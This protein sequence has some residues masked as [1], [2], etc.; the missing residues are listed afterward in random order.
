MWCRFISQ[1]K[2]S[3]PPLT[4]TPNKTSYGNLM[5]L[6]KALC[7]TR[8]TKFSPFGS[9]HLLSVTHV[10]GTRQAPQF[11]TSVISSFAWTHIIQ[12]VNNSVPRFSSIICPKHTCC[13]NSCTKYMSLK[14]FSQRISFPVVSG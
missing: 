9:L 6:L 1:L 7:F 11:S 3:N 13:S 4:T 8:C 14:Q 12:D 2:Y 10:L 5:P